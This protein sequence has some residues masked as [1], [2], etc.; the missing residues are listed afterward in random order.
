ME[1]EEEGV[2]GGWLEWGSRPLVLLWLLILMDYQ[3]QSAP[4]KVHSTLPYMTAGVFYIVFVL[5]PKKCV[6][7]VL[8]FKR[9]FVCVRVNI[10]VYKATRAS[11]V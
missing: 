3:S 5:C 2:E 9:A 10:V 11:H 4:L 6:A 7:C 8:I 1:E